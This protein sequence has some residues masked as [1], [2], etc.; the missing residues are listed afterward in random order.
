ML[1]VREGQ[2]FVGDV[3]KIAVQ[4]GR[5]SGKIGTRVRVRNV[6]FLSLALAKGLTL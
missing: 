2:R 3:T 1:L 6:Q 5:N 4:L